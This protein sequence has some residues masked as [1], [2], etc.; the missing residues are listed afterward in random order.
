MGKFKEFV[1]NGVG[2][3]K[4][5]KTKFIAGG[6]ALVGLGV[7][8]AISDNNKKYGNDNGLYLDNYVIDN[9]E[10]SD[11]E[12]FEEDSEREEV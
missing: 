5:H 6:I 9:D 11:N 10:D 12:T 3:V 8:K 1:N 7:A 4:K 2:F